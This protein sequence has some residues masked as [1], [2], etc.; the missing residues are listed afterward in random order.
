[1]PLG[2][3]FIGIVAKQVQFKDPGR[4][5]REVCGGN[6]RTHLSAMLSK[7]SPEHPHFIK[8]RGAM[9]QSCRAGYE[10]PTRPA[11]RKRTEAPL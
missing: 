10:V 6:L 7:D 9:N 1:M 11:N 8:Q 2:S 5:E 4:L 3:V